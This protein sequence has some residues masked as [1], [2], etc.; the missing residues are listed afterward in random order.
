[1]GGSPVRNAS[2]AEG[3]IVRVDSPHAQRLQ[4]ADAESTALRLTRGAA[5]ARQTPWAE[6]GRA[7]A[8]RNA[9]HYRV[10]TPAG[11]VV[12]PPDR[13]VATRTPRP[14]LYGQ[15]FWE[16]AQRRLLRRFAERLGGRLGALAPA[17]PRRRV[18]GAPVV[19]CRARG[20][21]GPPL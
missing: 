7:S 10:S 15:D 16:S 3:T 2:A 1:M 9:G 14:V 5:A 20:L 18:G 19:R 6:R 13:H 11:S 4:A 12:S 17:P 21:G 8:R